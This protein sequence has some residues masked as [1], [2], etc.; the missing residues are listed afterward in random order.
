MKRRAV[1]LFPFGLLAVSS[2]SAEMSFS[3][4]VSNIVTPDQPSTTVEVWAHF[5]AGLYAFA[6]ALW[7]VKASTDLGGFSDPFAV[8]HSYGT[9]D[10]FIEPDGDFVGH[11]LAG[12][13]HFPLN[14]DF[15]DTAN[16]IL[17]WRATWSTDNF[18]PR[19]VSLS[20]AT[21][22]YFVY[23]DDSGLSSDFF[24]DAFDEAVGSIEVVPAPGVPVVLA[25]LGA[26][27]IVRRRRPRA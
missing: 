21:N 27:G 15:A 12:Q 11:I 9:E 24:D 5:D 10:G 26:A 7:D 16:P 17:V 25:A 1:A 19:T 4:D 22:K 18:N 3:F 8:L 23:W 14:G 13:L 2:V 6:G 20:T